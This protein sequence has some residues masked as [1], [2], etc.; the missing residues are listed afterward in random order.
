MKLLQKETAPTNEEVPMQ[1]VGENEPSVTED[2]ATERSEF[3]E[4]NQP[5]SE[6][7]EESK[8]AT[9]EAGGEKEPT[10]TV[11]FLLVPSKQTITTASPL[12]VSIHQLSEQLS[13]D[14]KVPAS[15]LNFSYEGKSV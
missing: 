9:L 6:S 3:P 7:I 13:A 14:V 4:T 15:L 5:G 1:N 8:V 10:V 11:K 12:N 2:T